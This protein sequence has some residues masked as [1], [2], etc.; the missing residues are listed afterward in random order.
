MKLGNETNS[1]VN[2]VY[3]NN[4]G[5]DTKIEIGMPVTKLYWTDREVYVVK[6]ITKQYVVLALAKTVMKKDVY[7]GYKTPVKDK[8]GNIEYYPDSY[9][10]V[11]KYRN[12]WNEYN[13]RTNE[14]YGKI[15]LIFGVADGYRD[16]CF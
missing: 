14:R 8:H 3:S 16:P 2:W 7:N 13:G 11:R 12:K 15:S 9:I 10:Y 5:E 6:D 4:E 1:L